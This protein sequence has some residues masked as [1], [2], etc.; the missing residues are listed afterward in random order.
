[1]TAEMASMLALGLLVGVSATVWCMASPSD[2]Q[3]NPYARLLGRTV[4]VKKHDASE[5]E[6][7]VVVAVSWKGAV[8]VRRISEMT[9]DG[10]GNGF[11]IRKDAAPYRVREVGR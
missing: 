7:C 6:P 9:D 5:W 1:M 11:W 8:R 10:H 3:A 4:L 2:A